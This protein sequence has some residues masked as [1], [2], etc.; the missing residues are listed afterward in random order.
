MFD[1]L[2]IVSFGGP[3]RMEDVRPFLDDVLR[4]RDV[5]EAR[6]EEVAR[7][8]AR[9]GG[10]S[11]QNAQNRALVACVREAL[12]SR[13]LDL[14]VC[15][16][17]RNGKPS[18]AESLESL[19]RDGVRRALAFVTSAFGSYTGCRQ[20][21]E[22]IER[23][24]ERVGTGAPEVARLRCFF[25]HPCFVEACAFRVGAAL[26]RLSDPGAARLVFTAHSIPLAMAAASPYVL[27]LRE[28]CRLTAERAGVPAWDLVWQ[29]RS[30]P[31]SQPWLEPDI[32]DHVE[33][34]AGR[35]V[36]SVVVAPIGF[37]SDNL[38]VVW[39]LD[40]ELQEHA[41]D[42]GVQIL[43]AGTV[44]THA[45]YVSMVVELVEERI[46]NAPR[47]SIGVLPPPDDVCAADCCPAPRRP[48]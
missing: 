5:P 42:L 16:G 18:L 31:P 3:E 30:G 32:G 23:A 45:A 37:L 20:Y 24:R 34:L 8:Y 7:R 9:I 19:R 46:T 41:R 33:A 14:P 10:V 28:T 44:G 2:L 47:R 15:L 36:R 13:G 21:S 29:S 25:N 26:D 22:D 6:K 48:A 38:E 4:G 12:L 35:G 27:R 39:D 17:N 43:R 11:P 40:T 1:A